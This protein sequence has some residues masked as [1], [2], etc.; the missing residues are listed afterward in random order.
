[1]RVLRDRIMIA[2]VFAVHDQKHASQKGG[3]GET[4][5]NRWSG[6][7]VDSERE[8]ARLIN[9]EREALRVAWRDWQAAALNDRIKLY[10]VMIKSRER[11]A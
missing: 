10:G 4:V 3:T 8:R 6:R 1:M 7:S 11:L 9:E 2:H 5:S